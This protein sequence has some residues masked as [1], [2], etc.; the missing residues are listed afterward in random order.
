MDIGIPMPMSILL[1][2]WSL[3]LGKLAEMISQNIHR[4]MWS[5]THLY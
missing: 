1:N 5:F 3:L 2:N 4:K